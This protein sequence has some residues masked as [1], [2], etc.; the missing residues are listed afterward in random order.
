M[1]NEGGKKNI[2]LHPPSPSRVKI[3]IG[4]LPPLQQSINKIKKFSWSLS[5]IKSNLRKLQ[6]VKK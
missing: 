3:C 2:N 5:T 6:A 4:T 1:S